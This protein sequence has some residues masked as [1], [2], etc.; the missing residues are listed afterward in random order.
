M[1]PATLHSNTAFSTPRSACS[2]DYGPMLAIWERAVRATHRFLSETDILNLRAE[3]PTYFDQ[4][5]LW[6]VD[7][8]NR[9]VAFMGMDGQHIAML[10]VDPPWHR[11]GIGSALITFALQQYG[12]P[13]T[14]DVNEQ[15]PAAYAFYLCQGFRELGRSPLDDQGRPFPLLHLRRESA[16]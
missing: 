1:T 9:P 11:I 2:G 6:I 4:V 13:L 3:I 5:E 8:A 10:F 12:L 16:S 15:N 7:V 14:V